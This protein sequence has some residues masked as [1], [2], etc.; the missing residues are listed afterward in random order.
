MK[1][2]LGVLIVHG[3]GS[4]GPDFASEFMKEVGGRL[5][6]AGGLAAQ[7]AFQPAWWSQVLEPHETALWNKLY[8]NND[9]DFIKLRQFMIHNFADAVAY[10]RLRSPGA[11]FYEKIHESIR[12]ALA[13]LR[14]ALGDEDKP[15]I[16]VAHSLGSAI[17]SNYLW[18]Q[19]AGRK[20]K[21]VVLGRDAV[22]RL[23]TL[24]GLVTFGSNLALFSL[25][26]N[27]YK[28]FA[29]PPPTLPAN[30]L[31]AARWANY[32]DPDDVLGYPVKP[33][34]PEYEANAGIKDQAIN[35]GGLLTS[36]N[37]VSHAEYWTDD[38]FTVPVAEQIKQVLALIP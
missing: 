38:D 30:L 31:P 23:E 2:K 26:H 5:Q 35:V 12:S 4:Q 6:K 28:G 20:K 25:A 7:V 27:P 11:D 21:G 22:E 10:Q 24:A 1:P 29:F 9:L 16:V 3:M 19:Q 14:R 8:A 17:L 15:V 32:Y 13:D 18:D 37:P 36:W 34:C 33:L